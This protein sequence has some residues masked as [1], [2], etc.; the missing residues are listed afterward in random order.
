MTPH[1]GQTGWLLVVDKETGEKIERS[2]GTIEE[3]FSLEIEGIETGH[4]YTIDLFADLNGNGYYDAPPVDHAWRID[5]DNV[6]GNEVID[7]AHNT[8][9]ND[10]EWQ[11]MLEVD[12]AGMAPHVGQ[13]LTLYVRDSTTGDYLDTVI[14]SE[15]SGTEFMIESYVIDPGGTYTVDFYADLNGNGM[16]DVPPDDHAWRLRT[17]KSMGDLELVFTHNTDFTNIFETTGLEVNAPGFKLSVY[18]NPAS[19][20]FSVVSDETLESVS[21]I[22][23]TGTTLKTVGNIGS[24]NLEISLDGIAAGIYLLEVRLSDNA[25]QII[26][27]VKK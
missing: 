18:P 25:T 27:L 22:T 23:L 26:R 11:H 21:I 2:S 4:S 10:I 5:L 8:D 16:Y 3:T 9:F 14:I 17:A 12:F 13:M 15:I 6:D 7:F 19:A 1:N 20:K 24:T